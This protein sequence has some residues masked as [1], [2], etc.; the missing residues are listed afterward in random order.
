MKETIDHA[1]LQTFEESFGADKKNR[2]AMHATLA[3]GILESCKTVEAVV[4]NRHSFSITIEA[5]DITD[6]KKSGRCWMFAA[7]NVMRLEVMEKLNLKNMELSQAYPLFWDKLEK[8]NHFLENIIETLDEPLEGRVVSY[9]LKDPL[10]DGGQWDMFS[11]LIRKYGVV[12][13]EM[14]PESKASSETKTMDKLL[15][16]KL[17]QFACALREGNKEGK[18][19]ENLRALKETQLTSIYD[20]LCISIGISPKKFTY[21]T[22]DKDGKFIRISDITP[23]D[24]YRDYVSMDLDHYVSL[25][26]APT[27]DK[28]YGKTYTVQYLGN[29]RGGKPVCYLN[30]PIEELKKAAIAQMQD[31]KAVWFGSDVGQSSDGKSGMMALNT[32]DL[33]GLFSTSFLMDKAQR[34]DYGESLMTHAMVLTGVNLDDSGKP[35][36]WRVENSWGDEHGE[37]GFFVMSDDWFNEFTYQIV[38]DIKYLNEEQRALLKQKPIVLKPW[39]PMGSLAL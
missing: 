24:F 36:R 30:L 23:Q 3:N 39:D 7:L 8:S 1:T 9:L 16:L 4:E 18:S 34:L 32:Y 10:G 27:D 29:V 21:E 2:V 14:M 6:Q 28:P 17:R 19:L 25:I 15:T 26:N 22:R 31:G 12:P 33:E 11:N 5:G 37:K 35:N 20:M 38:V 13:K